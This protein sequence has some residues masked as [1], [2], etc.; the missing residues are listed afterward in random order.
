M[1]KRQNHEI[2]FKMFLNLQE[3]KLI[4]LRIDNYYLWFL[5]LWIAFKLIELSSRFIIVFCY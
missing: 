4:V 5:D 3:I 2:F 1:V